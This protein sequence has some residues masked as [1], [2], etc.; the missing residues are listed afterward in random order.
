MKVVF[1]CL[2]LASMARA[3]VLSSIETVEALDTA[4]VE[5]ASG[6]IMTGV[7]MAMAIAS[8]ALGIWAYQQH[9]PFDCL[10]DS[11]PGRDHATAAA[12]GLAS[13][14]TVFMSIGIPLWAVGSDKV[15]ALEKRARISGFVGK[16]GGGA[17]LRVS[18]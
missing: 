5:R 2:L 1:A 10:D 11:C 14:S 7:G 18:F 13:V 3:D 9:Q 8:T 17:S 15:G 4:R 12:V 6:A 16:S